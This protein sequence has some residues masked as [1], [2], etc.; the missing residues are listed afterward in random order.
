MSVWQDDAVQWG[1]VRIE[2]RYRNS[3]R[4]TLAISVHPDL[5]VTVRAPLGVAPD[6]I[7][8]AVLRRGAWI[9][10]SRQDRELYLPKQPPRRYVSG[11][12]H[13]YLGRQYRL[14]VLERP[15]ESVTCLRGHL[16]VRL[17]NPEDSGRVKTLL[18]RWYADHAKEVFRERL[19]VCAGKVARLGITALMPT[20][21]RMVSRWGSCSPRGR[22]TLNLELIK[23]PTECI[24][25]VMLHELCHLKVPHHGPRYWSLLRRLMPGYE[26]VRKKLNR[27]EF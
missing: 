2:Y 1:G 12:T 7:R 14:K 22:I 20:I 13:R 8:R 23:V 10:K 15:E 4:R 18:D 25:Y 26:D 17:K 11:E 3:S 24:D 5:A 21:R 19:E 16:W 6:R 27:L 9:E